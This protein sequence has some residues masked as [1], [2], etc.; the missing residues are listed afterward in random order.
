MDLC[1]LLRILIVPQWAGCD[2]EVYAGPRAEEASRD[3]NPLAMFVSDLI[4]PPLD[5]FHP[6]NTSRRVTGN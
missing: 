5:A 2:I 4:R 1:S 6:R 3:A